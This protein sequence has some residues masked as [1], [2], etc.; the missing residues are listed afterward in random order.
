MATEKQFRII[1]YLKT[2]RFWATA[3]SADEWLWIKSFHLKS[4]RCLPD[5]LSTES[6]AC[7]IFSGSDDADMCFF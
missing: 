2:L 3:E 7:E 5:V 4:V 6:E 1:C